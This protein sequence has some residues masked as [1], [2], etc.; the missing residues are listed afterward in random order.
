MARVYIQGKSKTKYECMARVYIQ[1][2]S[3]TKYK[4]M[5]RVYIQSESKNQE[6]KSLNPSKTQTR[7]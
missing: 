4:C 7:A 1:G 5:A 3:K 2:K 6:F